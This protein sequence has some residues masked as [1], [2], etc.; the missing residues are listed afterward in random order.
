MKIGRQGDG[1]GHKRRFE[2]V[3]ALE[4]KI[5]AYFKHAQTQEKLPTIAGIAHYLGFLAV[6]TLYDYEQTPKYGNS[7]KKAR[8]RIE[9][10][11][12]ERLISG[13]PPIGLIFALKNRF[14]WQDKQD[15]DITSG[16]ETLGV[17]QL[18]TRSPQ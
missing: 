13:K 15:L 2:T 1:G 16:G 7:I 8:L 9:E 14:K 6:G 10:M 3:K 17:V 5:D 4:D 12:E 11:L 18:P